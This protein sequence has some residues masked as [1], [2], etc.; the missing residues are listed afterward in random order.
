MEVEV[1]RDE[2]IGCTANPG[3]G[4]VE[5]LTK[6]MYAGVS[7]GESGIEGFDLKKAKVIGALGG[8]G[9]SGGRKLVMSGL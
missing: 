9:V 8:S 5:R 1:R 4:S 7:P 2:N 3:E 6:W